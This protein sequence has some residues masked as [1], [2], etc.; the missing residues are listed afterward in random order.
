MSSISSVTKHEFDRMK[1]ENLKLAEQNRSLLF[2]VGEKER[3]IHKKGEAI[4]TFEEYRESTIWLYSR[5][6]HAG[7][8]R[9]RKEENSDDFRR[10]SASNWD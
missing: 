6:Q 4:K 7:C 1:I 9:Q 10:Q 5:N 8:F 3:E 2:L